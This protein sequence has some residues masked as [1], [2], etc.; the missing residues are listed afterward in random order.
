MR[1]ELTGRHLTISPNMRRAIQR[2]LTRLERLLNRNALSAQVVVTL[3]KSRYHVDITLHARGEHFLHG[4]AVNK[5]F[6]TALASAAEKLERQAHK[7]T[8][9]WK[10]HKR[11][12]ASSRELAALAATPG[13]DDGQVRIIRARRYPVKPMSVEEAALEMSDGRSA[14]LVFRDASNDAVMV[15][16]RRPDGNLGLIEPEA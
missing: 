4:E 8:D 9:K 2:G 7:L 11:R 10:D 5:D 14:F 13:N 16:Y 15:L 1:L 6:E 12:A 3:E